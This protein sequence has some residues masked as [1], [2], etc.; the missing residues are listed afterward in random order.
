PIGIFWIANDTCYSATDTFWTNGLPISCSRCQI[1]FNA[2]TFAQDPLYS[3]L[4]KWPRATR[5]KPAAPG[6][7]TRHDMHLQYL[8][9][10][11]WLLDQLLAWPRVCHRSI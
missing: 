10:S 1:S 6:F 3:R 4:A 9:S 8:N 7:V 2:R 11:P 5:L